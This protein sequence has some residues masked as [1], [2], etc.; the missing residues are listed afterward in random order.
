[1]NSSTRDELSAACR[2][3]WHGVRRQFDDLDTMRTRL[4]YQT[5]ALAAAALVASL[6]LGVVD[7]ATSG[8]IERRQAEDVRLTLSQ[9]L[10]DRL[11]D[12]ELLD[13]RIVVPVPDSGGT[14]VEVFVGTRDGG[15]AGAAFRWK[16]GGGYS[17]PIGLMM[18]VDP[19]GTVL[20]VR[21]VAHAET[22]GLGDKIETSKS[23]W[24]LA[25]A[26][27]SLDNTAD[28]RWKVRKDGGDFDQFAGATITPR[29]VVRGV[30]D[31]LR[32]YQA[33]RTVIAGAA[34][35]EGC[36]KGRP[37]GAEASR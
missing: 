9:V 10:P 18:G 26:G 25:F 21:V 7:L 33:S 3:C 32:F 30:A 23:G 1:M 16:A 5:Y 2:H 36:I 12:N 27:R 19:E 17:G 35:G 8:A 20:G 14:A 24:I 6:V 28:E 22:P 13:C 15:F 11:H 4:D 37:D 34:G 29:A 31:A